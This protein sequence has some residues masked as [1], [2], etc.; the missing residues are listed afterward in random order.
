MITYMLKKDD[1]DSVL[2]LEL[3]LVAEG[4]ILKG[5]AEP[6][7]YFASVYFSELC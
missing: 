5:N 6:R 1:G 2:H 4:A 7:W 3:H